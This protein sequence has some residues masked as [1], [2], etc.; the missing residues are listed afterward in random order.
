MSVVVAGAGV[1]AGAELCEESDVA[2]GVV[3]VSSVVVGATVVLEVAGGVVEA[4]PVPSELCE[5]WFGVVVVGV[6]VVGVV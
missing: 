6:V 2:G 1:A 4:C 3:V 5:D